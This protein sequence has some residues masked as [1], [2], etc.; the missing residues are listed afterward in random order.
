MVSGRVDVDDVIADEGGQLLARLLETAV[1]LAGDVGRDVDVFQ[2]HG[3]AVFKADEVVVDQFVLV[4][5]H[6]I[7]VPVVLLAA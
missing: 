7:S 2:E 6:Q 1:H 4:F 5:P 3:V